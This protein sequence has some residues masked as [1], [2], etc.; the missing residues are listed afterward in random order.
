MRR[1]AVILSALFHPMLM[2]LACIVVATKFDWYIRGTMSTEQANLVYLIIALST[3]AFPGI[4]ILLL[5]WYGMIQSLEMPERKER[6]APFFSTAFFFALGYY[7]LRKGNLPTPVY[8]IFLG[9]TLALLLV[10]L[11]NLRWKIS[12][13]AAG[14]AGLLGC[15]IGLFQLHQF[16]DTF[17]LSIVLIILGL[18][19]TSRLM[20]N[21]HTPQ[22]VYVGAAAGFAAV[23]FPVIL[24]WII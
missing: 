18:V 12:V 11:I 23:Y 21:A 14:A 15:T 5:K 17:L 9:C 19:L 16:G 2:P 4:N 6:I 10:S 7:L 8:S 20:L 13:H 3:I 1:A 24:E 22:Q